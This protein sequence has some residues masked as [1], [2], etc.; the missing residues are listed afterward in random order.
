MVDE[1]DDDD[2]SR[3]VLDVVREMTITQRAAR[4][5]GVERRFEDHQ[6]SSIDD[7]AA[8]FLRSSGITLQG[9]PTDPRRAEFYR[10]WA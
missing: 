1:D 4:N 9:D 6:G 5:A 8:H 3:F 10:G 2:S 7:Y